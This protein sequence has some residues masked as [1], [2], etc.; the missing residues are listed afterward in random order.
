MSFEIEESDDEWLVVLE[1][2]A[3]TRTPPLAVRQTAE[4]TSANIPPPPLQKMRKL[5][6]AFYVALALGCTLWLVVARIEAHSD[7]DTVRVLSLSPPQPKPSFDWLANALMIVTK[8]KPEYPVYLRPATDPVGI[9]TDAACALLIV[10]AL[11]AMGF[12]LAAERMISRLLFGA[13]EAHNSQAHPENPATTSALPDSAAALLG[14]GFKD[15]SAIVNKLLHPEADPNGWV[16][17]FVGGGGVEHFV[18]KRLN[19]PARLAML[20]AGAKFY[21]RLANQ[22]GGVSPLLKSVLALPERERRDAQNAWV[23]LHAEG[24]QRSIKLAGAGR[25][26][27]EI[28]QE[29]VLFSTGARAAK[30]VSDIIFIGESPAAV[31]GARLCVDMFLN[32]G[33]LIDALTDLLDSRDGGASEDGGA[34]ATPEAAAPEEP[35]ST[36]PVTLRSEERADASPLTEGRTRTRRRVT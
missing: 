30:V 3:G 32:E 29:I 12:L 13:A 21:L 9:S 7:T 19:T 6:T 4:T 2:Q 17:H 20:T 36:S 33:P 25:T 8:P 22:P 26:L 27:G 23:K 28:R 1:A 24:A 10:G 11:I 14:N 31:L 34:A 5:H 35:T 15:S 16:E 18:G